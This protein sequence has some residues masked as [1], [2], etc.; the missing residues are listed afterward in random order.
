MSTPEWIKM[1]TGGIVATL[2]ALSK[3]ERRC[4]MS[5][6]KLIISSIVGSLIGASAALLFAPKSGAQLRKTIAE[7]FT[8]NFKDAELP[9]KKRAKKKAVRKTKT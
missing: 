8:F 2:T 7:P 6:Q 3:K 9:K 5:H 1:L 4:C